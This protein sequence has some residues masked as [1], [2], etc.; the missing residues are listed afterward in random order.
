MRRY[1]E[2][3]PGRPALEEELYMTKQERAGGRG[4]CSRQRISCAKR[5]CVRRYHV[6]FWK[7]RFW[8]FCF[9]PSSSYSLCRTR[10]TLGH[11]L[12]Q[13]LTMTH[14]RVQTRQRLEEQ[15][16]TLQCPSCPTA[17]FLMIRHCTLEEAGIKTLL[18]LRL[19]TKSLTPKKETLINQPH[20]N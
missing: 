1:S 12:E 11:N 18:C 19:D 7:L 6:W 9:T 14:T 13:Q 3:G 17:F 4:E 8:E 16:F 20:Q 10:S 15:P 2:E 5:P